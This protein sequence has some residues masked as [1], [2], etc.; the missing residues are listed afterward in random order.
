MDI[1]FDAIPARGLH[2]YVRLV[3]DALGLGGEGWY[4]Q[5]EPA[6]TTV[7]LPLQARLDRFPD[8]DVALLWDEENGWS[9]AVESHSSEDLIV[10]GYLGLDVLPGP[11]V[12]AQ[13]A[14][15]VM[16]GWDCGRPKPP[17]LRSAGAEDSLRRR[18]SGYAAS[19]HGDRSVPI[20]LGKELLS[21]RVEYPRADVTV[22]RLSGEID[23]MTVPQLD[24]WIALVLRAL[25]EILVVDLTEVRF[26]GS[27]GL[28]ALIRADQ[29]AGEQTELRVVAGDPSVRRPMEMTGLAAAITVFPS[30]SA[31]LVA[32]G[33]ERTATAAG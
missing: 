26:L 15:G 25:P 5:L 21:I 17:R 19:V 2:R 32:R 29:L 22:L 20:Q 27:A 1:E 6:S 7:Y 8:R 12:V 13:F 31:A 16:A 4:V 3:A 11:R 23:M 18:L 28:S 9:V 24:E 33:D 30:V 14:T 10:L